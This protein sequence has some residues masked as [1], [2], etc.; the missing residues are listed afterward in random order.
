[1][2]RGKTLDKPMKAYGVF[3]Q[4]GVSTWCNFIYKLKTKKLLSQDSLRGHQPVGQG[5][6]V[7]TDQGAKDE[8]SMYVSRALAAKKKWLKPEDP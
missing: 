7:C 5:E 6:G 8:Y 1:M 3:S 4:L 2:G